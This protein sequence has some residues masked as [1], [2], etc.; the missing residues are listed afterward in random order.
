MFPNFLLKIE[1]LHLKSN[2]DFDFKTLV[3]AEQVII[4]IYP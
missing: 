2:L 1:E 4:Q 3:C